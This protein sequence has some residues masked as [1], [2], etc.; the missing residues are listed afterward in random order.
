M[1]LE[2]AVKIRTYS[3]EFAAEL[4]AS[5]LAEEKI[6]YEIVTDDAGGA[7]PMLHVTKGVRLYVEKPNEERAKAVLERAEQ[8]V[9]ESVFPD[10]LGDEPAPESPEP[11][12]EPS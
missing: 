6:P 2:N 10:D 5:W 9:D 3:D 7:Y 12:A 8:G 4:A 1:I 11:P